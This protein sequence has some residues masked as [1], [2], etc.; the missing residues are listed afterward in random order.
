[1]CFFSL[2]ER[3]SMITHFSVKNY[4][5]LVSVGVPLTPI[6][7]IIGQ[8][9]SGKTSLL[10]AIHAFCTST[11]G[12]LSKAFPGKWQGNELVHFSA[13]KTEIELCGNLKGDGLGTIR[14]ELVV[15]FPASSDPFCRVESERFALGCDEWQQVPRLSNDTLVSMCRLPVPLI[16]RIR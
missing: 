13:E 4:K 7:V 15:Q 3:V 9:D 10:E 5:A 8:N 16:C 1:M 6:H 12:P 11:Q 14:Y 2:A